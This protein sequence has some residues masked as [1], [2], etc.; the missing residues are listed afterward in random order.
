[1]HMKRVRIMHNSVGDVLLVML[2]QPAG[3]LLSEVSLTEGWWKELLIRGTSLSPAPLSQVQTPSCVRAFVKKGSSSPWSCC[4]V[5]CAA[6]RKATSTSP[7]AR[8]SSFWGQNWVLKGKGQ[9]TGDFQDKPGVKNW[10]IY[11]FNGFLSLCH[12]GAC[13]EIYCSS[14]WWPWA[15]IT[16][17][18]VSW[19]M[20]HILSHAAS[21]RVALPIKSITIRNS[22][23]LL[24]SQQIITSYIMAYF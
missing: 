9:L 21:P 23:L 2:H 5:L 16:L 19:K 14:L 10:N 20:F 6:S 7:W 18:S 24:T 13:T 15:G 17:I 1:M 4:K 11:Q 12:K 22:V 3:A 8:S